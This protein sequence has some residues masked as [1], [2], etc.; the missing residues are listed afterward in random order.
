MIN[1]S[2]STVTPQYQAFPAFL[3]RTG[4]KNP[5]D[6]IHTVFQD[7]WN[8]DLHGFEWFT[9][10]PENLRYFN[11][12]M[13]FRRTPDLSWLTVYPVAEQAKGCDPSRAVYVNIGGGIGHQCAE[14]RKSF[15]TYLVESFFRTCHIPSLT[16]Y[17]HPE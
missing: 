10:H 1:P 16:L 3:K 9:E 13:A 14:S 2:F 12:F 5:T 17:L 11:D 6:E 4:Y 7:A 8:T 15:P